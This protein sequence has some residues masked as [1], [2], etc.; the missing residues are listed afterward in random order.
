V[1]KAAIEEIVLCSYQLLKEKILIFSLYFHSILS[2]E[3]NKL[4]G[5]HLSMPILLESLSKEVKSHGPLHRL[6][7]LRS[8][9]L[10]EQL[11]FLI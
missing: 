6:V 8:Y 11:C 1:I 7:H 2:F 4:K 5:Q 3:L 9:F 10:R